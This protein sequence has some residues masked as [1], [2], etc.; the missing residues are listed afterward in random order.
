MARR[1]GAARLSA[2]ARCRL[3]A[4]AVEDRLDQRN[5]VAPR[6]LCNLPIAPDRH[7]LAADIPGDHPPG[8]FRESMSTNEFLSDRAKR[9]GMACRFYFFLGP[10]FRNRERFR[11]KTLGERTQHLASLRTRVGQ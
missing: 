6:D 9:E 11:L 10:A 1:V 4:A 7:K 3:V 2:R 5:Y 8:P